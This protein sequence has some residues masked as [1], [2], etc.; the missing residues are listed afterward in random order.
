MFIYLDCRLCIDEL[1]L[2]RQLH[3]NLANR[4]LSIALARL[5]IRCKLF[6]IVDE[7]FRFHVRQTFENQHFVRRGGE[8]GGEAGFI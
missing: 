1:H 3:S 5:G 4:S 2:V 7:L 6:N 8:P